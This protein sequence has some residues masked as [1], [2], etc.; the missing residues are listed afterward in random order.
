M[1]YFCFCVTCKDHF[2]VLFPLLAQNYHFLNASQMFFKPKT[3][4][5]KFLKA[6]KWSSLEKK[7]HYLF[8]SSEK[9]HRIKM[10]LK[11]E[12][13]WAYYGSEKEK[14]KY[15]LLLQHLTSWC[16]TALYNPV[17]FPM[18]LQGLQIL[19]V[20]EMEKLRNAK[21]V[22]LPVEITS[23]NNHRWICYSESWNGKDEEMFTRTIIFQR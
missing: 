16:T 20:W 21:R 18:H 15:F 1:C 19:S 14:L 9:T 17:T 10:T 3:C 13:P 2:H 5:H 4:N 8:L 12:H 23:L 11:Q 22:F 7:T 6:G